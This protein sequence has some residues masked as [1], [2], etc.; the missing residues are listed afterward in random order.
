MIEVIKTKTVKNYAAPR[1]DISGVDIILRD[2]GRMSLVAVS[3]SGYDSSEVDL[4]QLLDWLETPEVKK[5][6]KSNSRVA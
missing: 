3:S 4:L 6:I 5:A 2:D 1:E